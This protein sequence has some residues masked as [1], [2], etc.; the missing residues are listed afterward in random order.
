MR[1]VIF[2]LVLL[3]ATIGFAQQPRPSGPPPYQ[4]PPT[5]PDGSQTPPDQMPPDME[6]PAHQHAAAAQ[7]QEQIMDHFGSEPTLSHTSLNAS[8]D[9]DSVVLTGTVDTER[10]HDDAVR[11][12]RSYAGDRKIVDK[13]NIR[14]QT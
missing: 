4:A 11:I 2:C 9:E 12:A 1:Y 14:K 6:A 13:I 5:L 7:I 3:L 8:V 10:E